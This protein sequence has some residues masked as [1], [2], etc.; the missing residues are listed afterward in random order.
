MKKALL[1]FVVLFFGLQLAS[2]QN[3]SVSGKVTYADDGTPIIGATIMVKGVNSSATITDVNGAY[4]LNVP[5]SAPEKVIV[6]SFIGM[7]TQEQPVSVNDQVVNFALLADVQQIESVIVTGYGSVAKKEYTGSAASIKTDRTKDV[8]AVSFES[9]MAG[10]IPGVQI[11]SASGAPGSLSSVRIRGMGSINAGNEPLYVIDGI[12][13]FSGDVNSLKVTADANDNGNSALSALNPND[14]ES[15]T[16]IKD[17]AAASL[18]GSRAANGVVVITTK[19]GV[20]GK[21]K[22]NAKADVGFTDMAI[23]YRPTLGGDARRDVLQLGMYNYNVY[24]EGMSHADATAD[25]KIWIDKF[26]KKPWNDEWTDWKKEMFRTGINQN[27]EVSASGGNDKTRF[28]ASMSYTDVQGITQQAEYDRITGR[29]NVN[30]KSGN[31]TL[32]AS[33]L[34]SSV[35]QSYNEE[36]TGYASPWFAAF[37]A[38]GPQDYVYNK[39]GSYNLTE[40]Y[41]LLGGGL[42]NP[43]FNNEINFNTSQLFRSF[44]NMSAQYEFFKGFTLKEVLSFD[45]NQSTNVAWWDPLSNNGEGAK[46]VNQ[47]ME[48]KN[49]TFVSQTQL[50][51][52]NVFNGHSINVLASF[53]AEENSDH[54]TY[55][56]GLNYPT[57][58][59]PDIA[60]ASEKDANGTTKH[61]TLISWV[62]R[63]DYNYDGRYYVGGSFRRDGTSRLAPES[64][65]GNFWSVSAAWRMSNE[66]WWRE[67]GIGTVLTDAKIRA[68]Y[69]VNGT[70]P[71]DWYGYLGLYSFGKNYADQPGSAESRIPNPNLKWEENHAANIG[72]DLSFINRI[73]LSVD[74]YNRDTKDLIMDKKISQTT[75]FATS[76]QNVGS[77]NNKGIEVD[78]NAIAIQTHDV[79]WSLGFNIGH[80][81]NTLTKL[82]GIQDQM[83]ETRWIHRIGDPYYSFYLLQSAGVDQQTG[84]EM[85]YKDPENGDFST[86]TDGAKATKAIVGSWEPTVQGGITSNFRWKFID[87]NFTFT[88]S[89]GG[90]ALNTMGASTS[91]GATWS[92]YGQVPAGMDIDKMWKKPGDIAELPMFT[93]NNPNNYTSSAY[94]MSTDHLRLKNIT[95]GFTTPREWF[96]NSGLQSIRIYGAANNLFTIK[97]KN[98]VVDPETPVGGV[99]GLRTPQ[100]RTVTIGLEINF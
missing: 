30:H 64:R 59:M 66:S 52:A 99:V 94:L 79:Q 72:I 26:A 7:V 4:K 38:V 21:V 54:Y 74:I 1:F 23:D 97:D 67:G 73:N 16:V 98:L 48:Q 6:A 88:Y 58:G 96:G 87:F 43:V 90:Q 25:A 83:V 75:G 17:A 45:Y 63:A 93:Y 86:V 70:R 80:N 81:K 84:L 42:A 100:M 14:I 19:K 9:R 49:M 92:Y 95:L 78:L 8:P 12:P 2:A 50:A 37:A 11:T 56:A 85:Y 36:E 61:E 47:T 60:N 71:N 77:M 46:G 18:Y 15:L 20:S 44:S 91:N 5:A 53:E 68:S 51:Y 89:L 57:S 39:D 13:V 76:L 27:Y 35:N 3:L 62:A 32:D 29:L 24:T 31:F 65:W 41:G 82:D 69:G 33:T 55:A 22:F 10:A 28:Y 34:I 40:G